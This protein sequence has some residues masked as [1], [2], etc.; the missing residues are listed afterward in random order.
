MIETPD[1]DDDISYE[2]DI[3]VDI[4][5]TPCDDI[6]PNNKAGL[7]LPASSTNYRPTVTLHKTTQPQHSVG[8]IAGQKCKVN[9]PKKLSMGAWKYYISIF[10]GL[11][12]GRV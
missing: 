6:H 1:D 3:Y 5:D 11:G 9:D 7:S 8:E 12:G 2:D 4:F 10:W